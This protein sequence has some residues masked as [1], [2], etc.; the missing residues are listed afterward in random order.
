[1]FLLLLFLEYSSFNLMVPLAT[2]Y[3]KLDLICMIKLCSIFYTKNDYNCWVIK[4][5]M[6][7]RDYTIISPSFNLLDVWKTNLDWLFT[8]IKLF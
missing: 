6:F 2:L 7:G 8:Q 4:N 5:V 1:M 3:L